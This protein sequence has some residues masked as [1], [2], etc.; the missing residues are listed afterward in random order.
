VVAAA[1]PPPIVQSWADHE[2]AWRAAAD[3]VEAT[4]DGGRRWR[5]VLK[6]PGVTW[7]TRTSPTAGLVESG[8]GVLVTKDAGRHWYSVSSFTAQS[9]IGRG[10]RLYAAN[11][12][13]LL[14]AE[15]WPPARVHAGMTIPMRVLYT[16]DGNL[17]LRVKQLISGGVIADVIDGMTPTQELVYRDWLAYLEPVH[18]PPPLRTSWADREHA[19]R[20]TARGIEATSDGGAHWKLVFPLGVASGASVDVLIRT[21]AGAGLASIAGR[22]WVTV[23]A[24]R[25]WYQATGGPTVPAFGHGKLLFGTGGTGID[26]AV[27]WPP[28]RVACTGRWV[29]SAASFSSLAAGPRP[30]TI[31]QQEHGVD[32]PMRTV[33]SVPP[34]D[35]NWVVF[36]R[37]LA[38][39]V[40]LQ[41]D[42]IDLTSEPGRYVGTVY[43]RNGVATTTGFVS[44]R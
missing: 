5:V 25:H 19:W 38:G 41:A 2:H 31:C 20:G 3:G 42:V 14:Q 44:P 29:H 32:I 36:G 17:V 40:E 43:Y 39:G 16:M 34:N 23:D 26:Q 4:S 12:Q 15:E 30:R 24:G 10:N 7:L 33:W 21:S 37:A 35:G 18:T 13:Q 8:D 6:T 11:G 9:A 1:S 22:T 28:R 27:Q